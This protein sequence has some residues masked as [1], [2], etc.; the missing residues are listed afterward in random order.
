MKEERGPK[1]KAE[2]SGP[3]EPRESCRAE[4]GKGRTSSG[5][6]AQ[7]PGGRDGFRP[8]NVEKDVGGREAEGRGRG[9][10][11]RPQVHT[12]YLRAQRKVPES[13]ESSRA[14]RSVPA[15]P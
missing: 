7:C 10:P 11:F 14:F 6:E 8:T 1:G 5:C 9:F 15:P 2:V 12:R 4:R 3:G 13:G